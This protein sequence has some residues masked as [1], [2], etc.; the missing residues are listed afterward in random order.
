MF[1]KGITWESIGLRVPTLRL[2]I[3]INRLNLNA[4]IRAEGKSL[5]ASMFVSNQKI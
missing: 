1:E 5:D 3:I 2:R 4:I